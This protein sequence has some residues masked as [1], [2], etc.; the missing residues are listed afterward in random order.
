MRIT[1]VLPMFL[2]SPAGGF[3]VVYEYAN[4]LCRRGH[5]ITIVHPRNLERRAG[6]VESI[7]SRLWAYKLRWKHQPLVPWFPLDPRIEI[8]LTPDLRERFIPKGEAIVAT[9]F[10]TAFYIHS[11][12]PGKGRKYYLIQSYEKWMGEEE[13]VRKSW[14]LPL[15][16]IV[17]SRWLMRLAREMG[18]EERSIYLPLGLDCAQFRITRPIRERRSPRVGMLAHPLEIKGTSDGLRAIAIVKEK[19]PQL[20][21]VFFGTQPRDASLPPWIEYVHRPT[22]GKLVDLYNS[23]QVFLHPSRLEGWG[24]PAAEAMAC[25]C[26]LAAAHN[27][28]V[29]EFAVAGENALLAPIKA[30]E[31]LAEQL[32]RLLIDEKL[33]IRLAETGHRQIQRFDWDRAVE[34]MESILRG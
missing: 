5:A 27:E 18:E 34:R 28:G 31:K 2:D 20:E 9:A 10:Q 24:L 8:R 6:L 26:A 16:K 30:P 32:W 17:V 7:K 11:Y 12:A 33:R 22:P 19:L 29:E 15:R 21:A 13:R 1:F 3:K 23:C 14:R 25:G 4:R